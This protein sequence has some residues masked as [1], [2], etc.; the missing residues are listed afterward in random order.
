MMNYYDKDIMFFIAGTDSPNFDLVTAIRAGGT[1]TAA[2]LSGTWYINGASSKVTDSTI[3]ATLRGTITLDSSGNITGGSYTRSDIIGTVSLTGGTV[4]IDNAGVLGGSATTTTD[5]T[6]NFA[7][8]KMN[9]AKGKM[10]L[11]GSTIGYKDFLFCIK[12]N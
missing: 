10:S 9:A 3:K 11:A 7:S 5:G 6:I 8:G 2:D 12:G 1:F 4:T